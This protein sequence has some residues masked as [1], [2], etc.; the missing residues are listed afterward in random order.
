VTPAL[1][2]C[3]L[4]AAL[5]AAPLSPATRAAFDAATRAAPETAAWVAAAS[6]GLARNGAPVFTDPRVFTPA[7]Q[8]AAATRLAAG[9]D[10]PEIRAAL[11]HAVLRGQALPP[12]EVV[13]L[14]H[15]EPDA[16]VRAVLVAGAAD[17]PAGEAEPFLHAALRDGDAGVRAAAVRAL[18]QHP[19]GVGWDALVAFAATDA[20]PEV[21]ALAVRHVGWVGD[22]AGWALA[23]DALGDPA[24]EVRLAALRAVE[25]LD[26]GRA[27]AIPAVRALAGDPDAA[28]AGAARRVLGASR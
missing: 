13:A 9:G 27:A 6:P 16:R 3:L 18:S 19:A 15:G 21:R 25:R 11:A 23:A 26:R 5:A 2:L 12:V 10:P 17:F 20:A 8:A 7:G 4:P 22:G 1:V 14:F 24:P 28:V